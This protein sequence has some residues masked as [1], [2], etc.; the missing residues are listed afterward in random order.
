[1]KMTMIYFE[2]NDLSHPIVIER[3]PR[4]TASEM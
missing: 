2:F 1:M 4:V 3:T